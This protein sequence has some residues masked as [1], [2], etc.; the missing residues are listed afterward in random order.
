MTNIH[1]ITN[2]TERNKGQ[3]LGAEERG[4]IQALKKKGLSNRAIT[5]MINCSLST[6]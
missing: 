4:A 1:S 6:I 3:Y 5:R 2:L